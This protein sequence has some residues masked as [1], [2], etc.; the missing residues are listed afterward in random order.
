MLAIHVQPASAEADEAAALVQAH[1]AAAADAV[2]GDELDLGR[3]RR[4]DAVRL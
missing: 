2:A 4:G 1:R 3:R